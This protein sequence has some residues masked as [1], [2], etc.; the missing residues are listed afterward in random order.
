MKS[1]CPSD[2]IKV[3]VKMCLR[4]NANNSI[5]V[6]THINRNVPGSP[7]ILAQCEFPKAEKTLSTVTRTPEK[8][9]ACSMNIFFRYSYTPTHP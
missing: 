4:A 7:M 2:G 5:Q 8:E 3:S 6:L 1:C 9:K